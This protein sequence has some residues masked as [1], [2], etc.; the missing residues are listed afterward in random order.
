VREEMD[1][2]KLDFLRDFSDAAR[3][4]LSAVRH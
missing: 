4:E 3:Q 2:G 1:S